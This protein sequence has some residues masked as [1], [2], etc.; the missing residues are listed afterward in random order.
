MQIFFQMKHF[1]VEK[2][3]GRQTNKATTRSTGQTMEPSKTKTLKKI[4]LLHLRYADFDDAF[5]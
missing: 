1:W 2:S 5:K 3:H 4:E